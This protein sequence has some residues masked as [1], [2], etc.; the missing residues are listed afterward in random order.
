M[1]F[2]L[3]V[4]TALLL[5]ASFAFAQG[6]ATSSITGV[7]K[8]EGGGVLPGATV[9]VASNATGT[10]FEA[11]TNNS[12]PIPSRR[13][14]RASTPSPS[15]CRIQDRGHQRRAR[16]AGHPDDAE[17]DARRRRAGGNDHRQRRQRGTDQH[18]DA[19]GDR[20]D[21]RRSDRRDSD[22]DAQR[23]ERRDLHGRRQHAGRHARIDDQRIARV[24]PERHA[25]RHQQQRHVQQEHR[26]LLLAG[27]AAPGCGRGRHGDD[28][29]R[30]RRSRRTRRRDHQLRDALGNQSLH[31]QRV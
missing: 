7:V 26:R 24:V 18:A 9:V 8:D 15:R 22:A 27:P 12:G 28:R 6:G 5:F 11:V 14:R 29:G 19:G 20:H 3:P 10:K 21:E 30:R 25:R 16:A 17:R 13:C 31:R 2:V 1:A 4:L 23:P